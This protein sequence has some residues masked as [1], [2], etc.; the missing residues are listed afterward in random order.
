MTHERCSLQPCTFSRA[1]R[2]HLIRS[3]RCN[4]GRVSR[5]TSGTPRPAPSPLR[6][7]LMSA[8]TPWLPPRQPHLAAVCSQQL[9]ALECRPA[10]LLSIPAQTCKRSSVAPGPCCAVVLL[11]CTMPSTAV[12][13]ILSSEHCTHPAL[14]TPQPA[15]ASLAMTPPSSTGAQPLYCHP[16]SVNEAADRPALGGLRY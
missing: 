2:R 3:L 4:A 16:H 5:G 12:P 15:G 13:S 14:R 1:Q 8:G 11:T 6:K 7:G 10:E 9:A